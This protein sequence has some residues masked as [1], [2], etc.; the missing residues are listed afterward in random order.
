MRTLP[1]DANRLGESVLKRGEF[2]ALTLLAAS[3][4]GLAGCAEHAATSPV[5]ARCSASEATPITLAIAADTVIDPATDSGCVL[6]PAN[7]SSTDNVEYMVV[8][9]AAGGVPGDTAPFALRSASLVAG[10]PPTAMALRSARARRGLAAVRFDRMLH[11]QER[12]RRALGGST[13]ALRAPALNGGGGVATIT[14]PAV[15]TLRTFTV[16]ANNDCSVYKPVGARVRSVGTHVAVYVDTL[17]PANGLDSAQIDSLR[18]VFDT[19]VY[20]VDTSAFGSVSDIDS[21]GV[22]IAVMTPLVNS[23]VSAAEC[24]TAGF[25]AGFFDPADLDP[26]TAAQYND[27]EIFYTIVADP[28]GAVS[29]VHTTA[30]VESFLPGTFLHELQHVIS[31]NQHV[32]ILRGNLEDLWLDEALSS[33]AEELGARSFLPDSA[34]FETYVVNDLSNAYDFL[35]DPGDHFL[36][37]TSDTVLEDFGAGWLYAR[38]LVDQF[39]DGITNKLEQTTLTGADNVA[40]QTG[41]PFTTTATR[42]AL[43]N[44]VSD[45]PGFSPPPGLF[46]RSWSF[47]QVYPSLF[48]VAF[49]LTP[50]VDGG[51]QVNVVGTLHAGSGFYVDIVQAPR[52][53]PFALDLMGVPGLVTASVVPRLD[54]IRIH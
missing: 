29:C 17:A 20:A 25:V 9:Q 8:A 12:L 11:Q 47:R 43:A 31:F 30:D 34:T 19:H 5:L 50:P 37:Q 39:G 24:Q 51:T 18:Q 14:P 49:P 28:N 36:L 53:L 1:G 15:G 7:G 33:L 48:G 40:A 42:W 52:A 26:A 22:V 10:A 21:N 23:L 3:L 13:R 44:W 54:V 2:T 35:S 4:A 38:Y 32:L 46:Y 16:C 45:L 27:G 41:L 6:L